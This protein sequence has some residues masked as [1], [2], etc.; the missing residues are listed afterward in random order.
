MGTTLKSSAGFS[1]EHGGIV[2]EGSEKG[3]TTNLYSILKYL[4]KTTIRLKL[5]IY[6]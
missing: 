3:T 6:H 1:F 4:A 5:K 2:V